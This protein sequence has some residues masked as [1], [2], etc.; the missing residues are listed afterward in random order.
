MKR[1]RA[2]L[3]D[4]TLRDSLGCPVS[5]FYFRFSA[6]SKK[7]E[8]VRCTKGDCDRFEISGFDQERNNVRLT[9]GR[10]E[11]LIADKRVTTH[12]QVGHEGG[13]LWTPERPTCLK[14]GAQGSRKWPLSMISSE[15]TESINYHKLKH[16]AFSRFVKHVF[17]FQVKRTK[18]V[19]SLTTLF[20]LPSSSI[21]PPSPSPQKKNEQRKGYDTSG[22]Y[23][24][25][26]KSLENCWVMVSVCSKSANLPKVIA[27]NIYSSIS[28]YCFAFPLRDWKMW[29]GTNGAEWHVLFPMIRTDWDEIASEQVL[30]PRVLRNRRSRETCYASG[31]A[32]LA[33]RRDGLVPPVPRGG[34]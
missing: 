11:R 10:K 24:M 28:G 20:C 34:T 16:L 4:R 31:E 33:A 21:Q 23:H 22:V 17:I 19:L 3:D 26:L 9:S 1:S 8:M 30:L 32:A 13:A 18:I 12:A 25:P 14:G 15:A 7:S 5:W 29:K 2:G 27:L 6:P